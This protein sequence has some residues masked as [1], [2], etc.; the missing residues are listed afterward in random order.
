M[1]DRKSSESGAVD[2]TV[3]DYVGQARHATA[4]GYN[5]SLSLDGRSLIVPNYGDIDDMSSLGAG[6][7]KYTYGG[8]N[9]G[10]VGYIGDMKI[11]GKS[12]GNRT[13]QSK[14]SAL[15][16]KLASR[17]SPKVQ[18]EDCDKQSRDD[19]LPTHDQKGDKFKEK[20]NNEEE[21]TNSDCI[22]RWIAEAPFWLKLIIIASIALLLGALVLIAVGAQ[23][24]SQMGIASPQNDSHSIKP[25]GIPI[26]TDAPV[27]FTTEFV[28]VNATMSPDQQ[29]IAVTPSPTISPSYASVEVI[30]PP[31]ITISDS[32]AEREPNIVSDLLNTSSPTTAVPTSIAPT[33]KPT[34]PP[35]HSMINL[36]VM[37][38][39]FDGEDT[40][41]LADGLQ[42]LPILDDNTI[43]IHLGDWNSPYAT[44]CNEDSFITN[45]DSYQKSSIP[46]YFVPGDN[47]YNDCPNPSEA[48]GFWNR[49][50]LDFETKYWQE[51]SWDV[52]RQSPD[53]KENFAF[54]QRDILFIGINLV[55]GI[56]HDQEEWNDR[57][58]A[59]I[60]WIDTTAAKHDGNF[61]TMVVFAHADPEIEINKNFFDVF[62]PMVERYEEQVIFVHRNLGIDTWKKESG[63]NGI[64]N[65]E[66]VAVEGSKWPPMWIQIDPFIG[67]FAIDQSSWYDEY[68]L[69]GVIPSGP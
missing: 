14:M 21:I 47:E 15:E 10:A 55:G 48:L 6:T 12:G 27:D 3:E 8:Y 7:S 56:V 16:K 39:R 26:Q 49:Y 38:G 36:F 5:S 57:H 11:V 34:Q 46:V 51:P 29:P 42:S 37:G 65:L 13:D 41:T 25:V 24:S 44:S 1:V 53:Y 33:Q 52:V 61:T 4:I 30:L 45:V 2:D 59:D 68:I 17:G 69:T 18:Y 19:S 63:Y 35:T 32:D 22:P 60:V 50:L 64:S 31:N 62:Y 67:T 43:L 40:K 23:L 58:E 66:V 20:K 9:G 28:P 54:L